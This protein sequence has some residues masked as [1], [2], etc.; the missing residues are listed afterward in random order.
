M[1]QG[2]NHYADNMSSHERCFPAG[3]K[4]VMYAAFTKWK[5]DIRHK[6]IKLKAAMSH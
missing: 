6:A 1:L 4:N 5:C 3:E 2:S